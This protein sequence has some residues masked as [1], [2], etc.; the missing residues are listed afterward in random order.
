MHKSN[1]GHFYHIINSGSPS[2]SHHSMVIHFFWIISSR[3]TIILK[4]YILP[5]FK[6]LYLPSQSPSYLGIIFHILVIIFYYLTHQPIKIIYIIISFVLLTFLFLNSL[7]MWVQL[8]WMVIA[9]R[10]AKF[11]FSV[12]APNSDV[13][14]YFL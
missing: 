10:I 9:R 8:G 14:A 13:W 11:V 2:E 1:L 6:L 12:V 4:Y 3:V 5:Y 7:K